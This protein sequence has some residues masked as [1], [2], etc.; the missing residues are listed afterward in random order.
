MVDRID[1]FESR[2][3]HAV[4]VNDWTVLAQLGVAHS[5]GHPDHGATPTGGNPRAPNVSPVTSTPWGSPGTA[6]G[7]PTVPGAASAG[8]LSFGVSM[9]RNAARCST[10]LRTSHTV[11]R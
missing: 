11:S 4:S 9:S 3:A 10:L 1:A 8:V 2:H 6:V 7:G 5:A